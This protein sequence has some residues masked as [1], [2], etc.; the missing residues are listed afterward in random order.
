MESA[1][2]CTDGSKPSLKTMQKLAKKKIKINTT[3]FFEGYQKDTS[4]IKHNM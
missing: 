3:T 1:L 2:R 4:A